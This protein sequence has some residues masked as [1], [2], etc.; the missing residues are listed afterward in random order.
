MFM[1]RSIVPG[2]A[3]GHVPGRSA[4]YE[5]QAVLSSS[6]HTCYLIGQ[7]AKYYVIWLAGLLAF[8][9]DYVITTAFNA[10][11]PQGTYLKSLY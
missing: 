8:V 3:S 5:N 2:R 6:P 7:D 1:C 9:A 11:Q 4:A 10:P